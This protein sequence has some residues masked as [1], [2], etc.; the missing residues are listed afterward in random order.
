MK[1]DMIKVI[2]KNPGEAPSVKYISNTL[3]AFQE[4]VGGYIETVTMAKDVVILC[5][6][7]GRL[8]GLPFNCEVCG[9]RFVGPIVF[10]GVSGEDFDDFPLSFN[11]FLRRVICK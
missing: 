4:L 7:E 10:V 8:R 2:V 6:E 5:N 3:E 1:N 11:E 9:V